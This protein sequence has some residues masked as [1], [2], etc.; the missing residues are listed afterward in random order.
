M[1]EERK[2]LEKNET[3]T[4]VDLPSNRKVLYTKW[5]FRTKRDSSGKI[6]RYKARLVVRGCSQAEGIDYQETYSPVI[7]YTS[8]RFLCALA[9]K[10]GLKMHQMDVTTAYLHGDLEKEIYVKPPK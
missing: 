7:R 9:V 10:Y 2:S 6:E 5:V 8:V 3:W 1:E 4:L